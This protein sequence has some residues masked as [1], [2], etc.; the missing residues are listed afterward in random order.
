MS[1]DHL[2]EEFMDVN[3]MQ[4][5][6]SALCHGID[7]NIKEMQSDLQG[8]AIQFTIFNFTV[9]PPTVKLIKFQVKFH[10]IQYINTEQR[11]LVYWFP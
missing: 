4:S 5:Q 6:F 8:N 11:F 7:D 1:L 9:L 10:A 2:E 3:V